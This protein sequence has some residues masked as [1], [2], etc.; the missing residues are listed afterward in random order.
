[1]PNK[2]PKQSESESDLPDSLCFLSP[3]PLFN[4]LSDYLKGMWIHWSKSTNLFHA[5]EVSRILS[6]PAPR[7]Q[8]LVRIDMKDYALAYQFPSH[9]SGFQNFPMWPL[10]SCLSVPNIVSVIETALSP[11]GRIIF[12][13]K[14]PAIL[15]IASES[16]RLACRI[17]EWSGLYVPVA[18]CSAIKSLVEEKGPYIL[19]I[20]SECRR[21]ISAPADVVVVDLDQGLIQTRNPPIV[22][23]KSSS[24]EKFVNQLKRAIDEVDQPGVPQHLKEAYT[25]GQ[26]TP[27]GQVICIKGRIDVIEDPL[28]WKQES[29]LAACDHGMSHRISIPPLIC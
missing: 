25:G 5:E 9:P 26:L 27:E 22:F 4:L 17:F 12:T 19:G 3:Y 18:H 20:T 29:V 11:S 8:D 2:D 7:L 1:M 16:T 23:L 13:S 15:N 24:R 6:F 21:L 14:H 28:W 10:F